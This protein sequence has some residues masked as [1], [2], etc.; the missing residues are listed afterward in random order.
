LHS[1]PAQQLWPLAPHVA[2]LPD[3]HT[4]P[5]L[6]HSPPVLL[7]GQQGS[8]VPPQPTHT[9]AAHT[10][11]GAVHPTPPPQQAWPTPPQPPPWHAA[12][13]HFP[14]PPPHVA[15]FA[16]HVLTVWSQ[17]APP[18]H[19]APSQ[20]G[21]PLPPQAAHLFVAA[22]HASPATVQK[23]APSPCPPGAPVQH[24]SP[25]PPHAP[26]AELRH[27]PR[28]GVPPQL[29]ASAMHSP[30]TQQRFPQVELWQQGW[31]P[32][33]QATRFPSRHTFVGVAEA[34]RATHAPAEQHPPP[35]QAVPV[36]QQA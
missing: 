17:Q 14:W 20:Q 25:S 35:S 31:L 27:M 16:T 19:H 26:Q 29:C 15:V 22:L 23:F 7:P 8:A 30:S 34:P 5:P 28:G 13:K 3:T 4:S 33:P 36:A 32:P 1:A 2:Q 12:L 18:P 10:E 11:N 9:F 21:C 24:V 6:H